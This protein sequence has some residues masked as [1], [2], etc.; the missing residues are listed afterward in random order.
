MHVKINQSTQNSSELHVQACMRVQ[1][2]AWHDMWAKS[3]R[4]RV[5]VNVNMD[6][7]ILL[8]GFVGRIVHI[9]IEQDSSELH[10]Q[11]HNIMCVQILWGKSFHLWVGV[12]VHVGLSIYSMDSWEKRAHE[13]QLF[14]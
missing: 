14:Q 6:L 2:L 7:N 5:G 10:V 8:I 13:N 1:I 4:L 9:K 11:A 3:L 12:N